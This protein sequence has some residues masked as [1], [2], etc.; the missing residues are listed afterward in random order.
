MVTISI[1]G[2]GSWCKEEGWLWLRIICVDQ[3]KNCE[4]AVNKAAST[5]GRSREGRLLFD[6][7]LLRKN[8]WMKEIRVDLKSRSDEDIAFE[9]WTNVSKSI[10]FLQFVTSWSVNVAQWT[11]SGVAGR[12]YEVKTSQQQRQNV[13]SEAI[14][15]PKFYESTA[16]LQSSSA[17]IC[18]KVIGVKVL[19][20]DRMDLNEAAAN[21]KQSF[22]FIFPHVQMTK[23]RMLRVVRVG[24]IVHEVSPYHL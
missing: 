14:D 7:C 24:Q 13:L 11:Q 12:W 5:V 3:H 23:S 18:L 2:N 15:E 6:R 20:V 4:Y 22:Q 17:Y 10:D 21:K 16:E 19:A 9:L 8:K 1:A